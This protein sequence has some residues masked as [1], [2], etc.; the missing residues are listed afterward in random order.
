[1][2]TQGKGRIIGVDLSPSML[3]NGER[4]LAKLRLLDTVELRTGDAENI[5]VQDH[6]ADGKSLAI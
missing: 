6:F 2:Q 4:Q 3:E 5:P 1:L